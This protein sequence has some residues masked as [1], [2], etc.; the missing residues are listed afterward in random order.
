MVDGVPP[1]TWDLPH[2]VLHRNGLLTEP[3]ER[4]LIVEVTGVQVPPAGVTVTLSFETQRGD[5]DLERVSPRIQVWHESRQITNTTGVTQTGVTVILSHEFTETV[6]AGAETV[7]T[8]T[9]YLRYDL[10]VTDALHPAASLLH[11]VGQDYAFL[12]E[13]QWIVPLPEVQET[14]LG[15]A[16]DELVVYYCDMFPFRKDIRDAS[17]WLP[18]ENVSGYI[19]SELIPAMIEAYRVQTDEWEFPWYPEWRGHRRGKDAERLSVTL[20]DGETW[21]HGKAPGQGNAGI[22]IN[23]SLGKVEYETLT[24]GLVSTFHHEL[25]HNHQRN[26]HLHLGGSG[27]VGGT[28]S[29]WD[30][31]AEGMAVLASSVGQP[32]VQFRQTWGSRAYVNNAK[33][34]LGREGISEGDLNKSYAGMNDYHGAT[35]WRFLY[36]Q[37]GGMRD[38]VENPAAGMALIR[39]V[40]LTLYAGDIVDIVASTDVVQGMPAILDEALHGS[41]CPFKTYQE[42][43]LAFARAIYALRLDGGRCRE[44]GIPAGCGLYDPHSLYHNPPASTIIYQGEEIAYSAA[45]QPYPTGIPSSFGMDLIEVELEAPTKGKALT[46]EIHGAPGSVAVLNVQLWKSVGQPPTAQ[47]VPPRAVKRLDPDGTVVYIIPA[48]DTAEQDRLGLIITRVDAEERLDRDG[49]Y[50]IVLRP[51]AQT[52]TKDL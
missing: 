18:R 36:E 34:F 17:T 24:D 4:S 7:A 47:A 8:P 41:S 50:T 20:S 6:L 31:F 43:L 3:S 22:S 14:S 33:E 30:F 29:A 38:G 44:P 28:E 27:Q 5:P 32:D 46:M 19:Y 11:T 35:Y 9:D 23:V 21:F 52:R 51:G 48:I 12:L 15:A 10:V 45:E 25:F 37:C 40:L 42:S 2:L 13:N 16:P 1:E 49:A 39:K 26:I